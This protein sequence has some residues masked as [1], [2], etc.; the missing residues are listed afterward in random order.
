[1]DT[2]SRTTAWKVTRNVQVVSVFL[3]QVLAH[4][5]VSRALDVTEL[6]VDRD[7]G[8]IE[9]V[10]IGADQFNAQH[11]PRKKQS[12]YLDPLGFT[13]SKLHSLCAQ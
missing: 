9:R 7:H 13:W 1:M 3:C 6:S 8:F 12:L 11:I 10:V 4:G 5:E 2:H